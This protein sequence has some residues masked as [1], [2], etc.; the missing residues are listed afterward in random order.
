MSRYRN[1]TMQNIL[2]YIAIFI[3]LIIA[4][5]ESHGNFVTW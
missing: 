2:L 5:G 3:S 1:N 4:L